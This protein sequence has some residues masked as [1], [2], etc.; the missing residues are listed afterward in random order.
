MLRSYARPS[1]DNIL[2]ICTFCMT[3]QCQASSNTILKL[4]HF[5]M[6]EGLNI[7]LY[8]PKPLCQTL[9]QRCDTH[10]WLPYQ[11][12]WSH[13]RPGSIWLKALP[14]ADGHRTGIGSRPSDEIYIW[15]T[16]RICIAVL[17]SSLRSG[18]PPLSRRC[19]W[20][21]F[22]GQTEMIWE[23]FHRQRKRRI[24]YVIYRCWTLGHWSVFWSVLSQ[25]TMYC[26]SQCSDS[27]E[28]ASL[29]ATV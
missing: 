16:G 11:P 22:P 14:L 4:Q 10:N 24:D 5:H 1:L 2:Y 12:V 13:M 20:I 21:A 18:V 7:F 3:F 23:E 29:L 25:C 9:V 8:C 28:V 15:G 17:F 27:V 6:F 26:N 19:T